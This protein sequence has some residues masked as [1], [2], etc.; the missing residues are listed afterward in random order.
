MIAFSQARR[1]L[2]HSALWAGIVLVAQ[3]AVGGPL[4]AAPAA[5]QVRMASGVGMSTFDPVR[6]TPQTVDYLRPV[7]DTLVTRLGIDRFEPCLATAWEFSDGNRKL[8]L[9]LRDGVRF[10]DG[11]RFDAEAVKANLERG[12]RIEGSPWAAVYRNIERVTVAGPGRI[13]LQLVEPNPALLESLANMPGMMVSP[14]ALQDETALA[15][16]PVGTG[17]WLLDAQRSV[18]GTQYV[19][20]RNKDYWNPAAQRVDTVFI[21]QMTESAARV[22]ALRSGQLDVATVP[23]DQ[24]AALEKLGFRIAAANRVHYLMAVWDAGGSVVKP[25]A[26]VRVRRAMSLAIDRQAVLKVI[27]GGRGTASLNFFPEGTAGHDSALD[28]TPSYDPAKARQL[29]REAGVDGFA[30]DAV[31]QT[32]NARFAAAV[33][34]EL[35]KVGIKVNLK[36]MPDTGSFQA[37][38]QHRQSPLGI[39]AHQT[40]MPE[41][42]YAS[43]LSP[44]GR[45]NPFG[46]KYAEL[47]SLAKDAARQP[48]SE[49]GRLYGALFGRMI[50]NEA[51]VF[52]VVH[53]DIVAAV[54]RGI[55]TGPQTFASAGLPDPRNIVVK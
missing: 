9:T 52:P 11:A 31:V 55:D 24:A 6:A 36:T 34:G 50:A 30:V 21:Q 42:L 48:T 1:R 14:K 33:A 44:S 46:L 15:R 29:L 20:A 35:A 37:A 7:Y 41:T 32:N 40:A 39:F 47:E 19:F 8:A 54:R 4:L 49:A 53:A 26:D 22:N 10:S 28:R 13:E 3:G 2:A 45:Y 5:L 25:L 12:R 23:Q 27:F 18:H 17:G 43:L 38:V 16:Q 51:V